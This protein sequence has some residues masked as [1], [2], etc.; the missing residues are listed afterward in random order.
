MAFVAAS[1]EYLVCPR[2]FEREYSVKE[3]RGLLD[4]LRLGLVRIYG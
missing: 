1:Y 2:L 4:R 3:S